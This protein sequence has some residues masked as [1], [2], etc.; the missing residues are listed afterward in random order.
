[1]K[2]LR[3]LRRRILRR[4]KKLLL[5]FCLL[6]FI[7]STGL[8]LG[9]SINY[10]PSMHTSNRD[11]SPAGLVRNTTANTSST[12]YQGNFPHQRHKL[13]GREDETAKL[14]SYLDDE[15]VEVVIIYSVLLGTGRQS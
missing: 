1:M 13:I 12:A 14:T 4:R 2:K 7:F 5:H 11:N 15:A 10:W 3:N 8:G 9:R 6:L